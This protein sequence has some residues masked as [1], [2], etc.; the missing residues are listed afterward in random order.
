MERAFGPGYSG[1]RVR[2]LG[3][4]FDEGAVGEGVGAE[5]V[6]DAVA[7][8]A[9]EHGGGR[10]AWEFGGG[11]IERSLCCVSALRRFRSC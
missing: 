8:E 11:G 10:V 3:D 6:D 5:E 9:S 7:G 1:M 4:D 2:L